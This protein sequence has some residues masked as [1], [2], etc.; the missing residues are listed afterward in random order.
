MSVLVHVLR[1]SVPALMKYLRRELRRA[2]Y[3]PQAAETYLYAAGDVPVLL[4]A[5]VDTVHEAPPGE[6]FYDPK[7]RVLWSPDGLGADDRAGVF[8]ILEVIRSGLR[9]HVLFTDGEESG[10]WG[11]ED[12][13]L[14]LMA[15]LPHAV[16]CAVELDRKGSGEA[17]YYGCGSR[18]LREWVGHFGFRE[19]GGSF[20]DISVLCP[21]WDLAGV[22]LSVGYYGQHTM[23]EHL[24]LDDLEK[25][26]QAVK[27][28][29][30]APPAERMPYEGLR[31]R[32]A[33][34]DKGW[35]G[36]LA[37]P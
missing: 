21:A 31:L 33:G 16:R 1:L 22:N 26:I 3:A 27:R 29:L 23:S 13:A 12:A 25:T 36:K 4:V 20:S 17:V 6:V 30:S 14:D 24:R 32:V 11:A 18:T 5:H 10:G 37:T 9:P 34:W 7:A 15:T 19:E 28:M 2:G 35:P 8:A